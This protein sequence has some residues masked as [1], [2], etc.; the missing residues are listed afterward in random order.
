MIRNPFGHDFAV[1]QSEACQRS[2]L[3]AGRGEGILYFKVVVTKLFHKETQSELRCMLS[4]HVMLH[5]LQQFSVSRSLVY[6]PLNLQA[7]VEAVFD[8]CV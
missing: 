8:A 7:C 2:V 5:G 4:Q 3:F 1:I 6:W